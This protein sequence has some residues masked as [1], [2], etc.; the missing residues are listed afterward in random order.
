VVTVMLIAPII[1]DMEEDRHLACAETHHNTRSWP[2]LLG[3]AVS[4]ATELL[5]STRGGS[6][7]VSAAL[8]RV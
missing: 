3:L 7:R 2:R 8:R 4:M 6:L 1:R 5:M